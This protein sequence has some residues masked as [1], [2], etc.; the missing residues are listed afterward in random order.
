MNF[1]SLTYFVCL[2]G[3]SLFFVFVLFF[4]SSIRDILCGKTYII[5]LEKTKWL[6]RKGEGREGRVEAE[7]N[8]KNGLL[9][10]Y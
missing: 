4:V 5:L 2:V 8:G 9:H 10:G 7:K 3:V 1:S 6:R